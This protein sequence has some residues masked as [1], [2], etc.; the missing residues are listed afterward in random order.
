MSQKNGRTLTAQT[1]VSIGLLVLV[2]GGGAYVWNL[3]AEIRES[4][5]GIEAQLRLVV[6]EL[7]R[8]RQEVKELREQ[9]ET[10]GRIE[11]RVN[12][13]GRRLERME[14]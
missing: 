12:E 9:K 7:A 14:R 2:L 11:E 4:R 3:N 13:L 6:E 8:L 10:I 1:P 5:A